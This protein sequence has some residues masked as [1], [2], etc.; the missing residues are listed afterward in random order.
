MLLV[1]ICLIWEKEYVY[2]LHFWLMLCFIVVKADM[3]SCEREE[4]IF[5]EG[6]H[7]GTNLTL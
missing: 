4:K 6:L 1:L 7:Q 5:C 2:T 3:K